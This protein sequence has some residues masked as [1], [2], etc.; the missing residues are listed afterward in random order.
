MCF[1]KSSMWTRAT[2]MLL[3]LVTV[4]LLALLAV[5]AKSV[6][7]ATCQGTVIGDGACQDVYGARDGGGGSTVIQ[8]WYIVYLYDGYTLF[9]QYMWAEVEEH[10]LGSC[11]TFC[12]P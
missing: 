4:T 1:M 5:S 6:Y 9:Q 7:A 8:R 10:S 3:L 12:V 2:A 11:P